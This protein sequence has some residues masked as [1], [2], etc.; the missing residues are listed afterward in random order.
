MLKLRKILLYDY[1]YILLVLI[2]LLYSVLIT[3]FVSL[4]SKY[5]I[6]DNK[7]TGYIKNIKI[8]G[9]K[10]NLNIKGKEILIINYYFQTEIE[11]NNFSYKLG[12]YIEASGVMSKPK[13]NTVFNL[14]N[15]KKY[16]YN[17]KIFFIM[18][19]TSINKIK[20]NK[21]ISYKIKQNI[22]DKINKIEKSSD[23]LKALILG[24]INDIDSNVNESYQYNGVNHLFAISGSHISFLA[25]VLLFIFKKLK[26]EEL[27]RYLLVIG[28]LFFYMFLTNYTGSVL[29]STIFFIFLSFNKIYYFNI[30]PIN[31][32][33]FTLFI[34]IMINPY[35]IYDIGFQFSFLISMYLILYQDLINKNKNYIIKT[36]IISLIAFLVSVPILMYNFFQINFLSPLINIIFVPFVTLILFPLTLITFMFPFLDNFLLIFIN[37][38]ESLSLWFYNIKIG[39]F[40]LAKPSILF[41]ILYFIIITLMLNG[42]K[43]K[44]YK[45]SIIFLIMLLIHH[46]YNYFINN[47]YIIFIDVGQGDSILI[48]LPNNKGTLLF[49]TGGKLEYKKEAWQEKKSNYSI[50]KNTIIPFLKSQGIKKLDYLILTHGDADHMGESINIINSIK[51]NKVFI[52]EG[53]INDL[54]RLLIK[55]LKIKKI[56]YDYLKVGDIININNYKFYVLNPV[57]NLDENSNSVVLYSNINNHKIL[58][59]GD[60]PVK[61]EEEIIKKYNIKNIEILKIGHHGSI[62]STS[63]KLLDKIKPKYGFI[64]VGLNNKFG[65]PSD[66]IIK[67]LK[68]RN[69][70]TYLTSINGSI[71]ITLLKT[72]T[73]IKT[74]LK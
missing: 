60:I 4:K 7:V 55:N 8:D 58:L 49:D 36:L 14:F 73:T 5:N 71:K 53:S 12:D 52:N 34:L 11:K 72:K 61:T 13:G 51:V 10:L 46:N 63:E 37:I 29:R 56:N 66:I 42:L 1:I 59:T 23:Y 38:M 57:N 39:Q 20:N 74:S 25:V 69:I 44:K 2:C 64:S 50:G 19:A 28:I 24:D 35:L 45:F 17:K 9:N 48:N 15:Y 6:N 54:E 40:I 33:W 32:L 43:N 27:K 70:Q 47:P 30:K 67:R 22:I 31:I 41:F 65:H 68:T 18:E 16:L 26:I 21:K 62:T 3:N